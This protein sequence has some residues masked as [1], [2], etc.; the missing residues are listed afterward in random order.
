MFKRENGISP[1]LYMQR[2]QLKVAVATCFGYRYNLLA[3]G[4]DAVSAMNGF[5]YAEQSE[6]EHE[7]LVQEQLRAMR[8]ARPDLILADYRHVP[9]L[10]ELKQIA[11]TVVLEFH[12]DWRRNH[13]RI[14]ELVGREKE[15]E[16]NFAQLDQKIGYARQ[17]LADRLHGQTVSVTRLYA[18]KI[19]IQGANG[20]PLNELLYAE[21]GLR[22]GSGVPLKEQNKQYALDSFPPFETDR[23]FIYRHYGTEQHEAVFSE[24]QRSVSWTSMQAYRMN[25]VQFIENWIG[26]S[27]TPIGQNRIVDEL[28]LA[29]K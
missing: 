29:G 8:E 20:H 21:L 4:V 3:L 16:L 5:K 25:R 10:D 27:W 2:H 11:P 7:L 22:P 24:L 14:A 9:F 12:Y 23:L 19:R 1:T 6:D 26:M 13:R 17:L 18:D 15:A 28:L